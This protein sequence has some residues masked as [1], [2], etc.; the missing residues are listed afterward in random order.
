MM[1]SYDKLKMTDLRNDTER[2][3]LANFPNTTLIA[4]G[5]PD[6]YSAWNP[7]RLF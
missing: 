4:K 3:L 7:L 1:M 2:V 6:K 5:F